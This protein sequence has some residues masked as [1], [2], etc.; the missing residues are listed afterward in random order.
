M[1]SGSVCCEAHFE[2]T[3][4]APTWWK[5]CLKFAPSQML[6]KKETAEDG[7]RSYCFS[8]SLFSLRFHVIGTGKHCTMAYGAWQS[9]CGS[10][11][12][13]NCEGE[14]MVHTHNSG[15]DYTSLNMLTTLLENGSI[16]TG[17]FVLPHTV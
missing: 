4:K 5:P 14:K 9:C 16:A 11:E 3:L 10:M 7:E 1:S 17:L 6:C 15:F 2:G 8:V 13:G 12:E